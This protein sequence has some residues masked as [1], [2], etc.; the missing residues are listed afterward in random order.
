MKKCISLVLVLLFIVGAAFA[1]DL[2]PERVYVRGE[3][4]EMLDMTEEALSDV[5]NQAYQNGLKY[6]LYETP[7]HRRSWFRRRMKASGWR[8]AFSAD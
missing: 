6:K 1:E 7:V 3:I 2:K 4:R 5:M 8:R